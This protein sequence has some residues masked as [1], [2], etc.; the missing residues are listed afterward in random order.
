MQS[1]ERAKSPLVTWPGLIMDIPL[2]IGGILAHAVR[3]HGDREIVSRD[4][5]GIFR[6]T[7]ADFGRRCGQLANALARLGVRPGDCVASFAWNSHRHLELYYAV[8][9]SGAVLHT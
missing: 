6:Y 3:N 9:S 5:G 1:E 4:A 2:T 7:Y 8:P